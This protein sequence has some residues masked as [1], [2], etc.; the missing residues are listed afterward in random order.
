MGFLDRDF[1]WVW[2]TSWQINKIEYSIFHRME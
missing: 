1:I 2:L